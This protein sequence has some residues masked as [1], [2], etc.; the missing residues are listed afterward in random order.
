MSLNDCRKLDSSPVLQCA[1]LKNVNSLPTK[2]QL[3]DYH[4]NIIN[5][6]PKLFTPSLGSH[7]HF[8]AK[9]KLVENAYPVQDSYRPISYAM[10]K[11][12][13]DE[14]SRLEAQDIIEQVS[15]SDWSSLIIVKKRDGKIRLRAD[16]STGVNQSLRSDT[17]PLPNVNDTI[18]KFNNNSFFSILD[19]SEAF[20]QIEIAEDHRDITTITTPKGLFR[21]KRLP[22]GIKTAPTTFEQAMDRTLSGLKGVHD[23]IDDVIVM[24]ATRSEHDT[25]LF[26]TLQRLEDEGWKLKP[27][28]CQFALQEIKYLG[29]IVN[30]NGI[31]AD[32]ESA[33]AIVS[34]PRPSCVS[35]V[36]SLLGMVNHYG[37][38]IPHLHQI[39]QPLEDLTKKNRSWSWE[40]QHD[41]AIHQIKEIMLSPLLLEHFDPKKTLVVA[42]DA[43]STGIGGVL[44]QRDTNGNERTVYHMSQSLTDAQRNYSQL[45]KEALALMTAVE[46]LHK[47]FGEENSSYKQTINP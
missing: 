21:F 27:E 26:L 16:Y 5:K 6:F 23:Y 42:A 9:F 29:L 28:K 38:F 20:M 24:G 32:P 14:L 22:F 30:K 36:Q 19:L 43:C 17:Y 35:E 2:M 11:L 3:S 8:Q 13:E 4:K 37:K 47:F 41:A 33:R 44:L 12:L 10:E 45:E 34:M 39:K 31:A 18:S 15:S 40:P 25:R 7:K 1:A 46:R